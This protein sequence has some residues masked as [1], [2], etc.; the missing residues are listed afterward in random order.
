[1]TPSMLFLV[2]ADDYDDDDYDVVDDSHL[3]SCWYVIAFKL[4]E[5][6]QTY[7]YYVCVSFS[8]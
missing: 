2:A 8:E 1:M 4:E 7:I 3:F 6:L 5:Y